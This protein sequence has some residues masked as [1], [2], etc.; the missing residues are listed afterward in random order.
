[1]ALVQYIDVD[2]GLF[3]LVF[4]SCFTYLCKWVLLLHKNIHHIK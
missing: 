2:V 1:M 3:Y 4:Q